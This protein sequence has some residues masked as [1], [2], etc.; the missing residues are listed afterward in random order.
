MIASIQSPLKPVRWPRFDTHLAV[1]LPYR[2]RLDNGFPDDAS[3][4][5][6]RTFEDQIIDLV[7]GHGALVAHESRNGRRTL[8]IY[9]DGTTGTEAAVR[10]LLAGWGEGRATA[11]AEPDP[12]W[13]GI[14]HLRG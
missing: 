11:T 4:A 6:L 14:S 5:A 3:L 8:H 2:H 9:L 13:R 7:R 12:A 1:V 10:T